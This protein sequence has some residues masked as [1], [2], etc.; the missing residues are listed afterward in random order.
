MIS[1][2]VIV[3]G[4]G[5]AGEVVAGRT[6]A[7]GLRVALVERELVGGECSYWGCVPSKTLIRPGDVV[8]AA[9][10]VPGVTSTVTSPID[11]PAVLAWR[12]EQTG[13][14]DDSG[15]LPWLR[16]HGIDL[17]RGMA[18][19]DGVRHVVVDG[20]DG[21][22]VLRATRAVVLA[23]GTSAAVPPVE[24]LRDVDPWTS[25]EATSAKEPP[26]RL[27]VIGG[28]YVGCEM[29][30]AWSALGSQVTL[31][32]RGERLLTAQEPQA[33]EAV[34]AS[35]RA[36]GV[37][38]RLGA[39]VV[40]ARREGTDVVVTTRDG[41]EFLGDEVL[42]ATGRRPRTEDVG[43]DTVGLTPGEHLDVDDSLQVRGVPWLYGAGDVNERRQLT[44]MG[45]YQA[46]Q[47]AAAIV[48]RAR[49][50]QVS[51]D[52]WSPFVAT[53]DHDA[54][55]SVVFTVPQVASV[56]LTAARAA[57][58]GLPHRVV[59]YPIG[60]VAG[61]ALFADG[62]EGTAVAVVDPDREVLLG[63]TFVGPGV[64]ELLHAATIAV[65]GEVP[66]SRLWHAV[67][68]YPTVSEIWLR[69]LETY[70]G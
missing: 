69:L 42:V 19:L 49:G 63:V 67:P 25:R 64:A 54:T 70:R 9:S 6:A 2:D 68:A 32:A 56:G 61:A 38:V 59:E 57:E 28:G 7:A 10:R 30:T 55:P 21:R 29:T 24:G 22:R 4:A 50:E 65:V 66:I 58:R 41:E 1:T 60:S 5:P 18:R 40:A 35:L 26:G 37:E 48:A 8:A 11:V 20:V 23:T 34:L 33:S 17:V 52:A 51:L 44:H 39:D 53:A 13:G 12:D 46:R 14:W 16:E 3:I 62:Y 43:L 45:K 15:A 31:L 36:R 47:A 27:V